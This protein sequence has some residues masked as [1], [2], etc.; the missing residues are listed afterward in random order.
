MIW[1]RWLKNTSAEGVG[2][3]GKDHVYVS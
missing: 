1:E 2:Q 3:R